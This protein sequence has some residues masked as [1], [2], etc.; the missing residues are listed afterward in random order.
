MATSRTGQVQGLPYKNKKPPAFKGQEASFCGA[1]LFSLPVMEIP[2][3]PGTN[4]TLGCLNGARSGETYSYLTFGLRLS[5]P[6]GPPRQH[7]FPPIRLSGAP[8]EAY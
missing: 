4:Y 2:S 6:F 1:T 8:L 3:H 5:G 7:R